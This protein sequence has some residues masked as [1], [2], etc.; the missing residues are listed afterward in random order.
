MPFDEEHALDSAKALIRRAIDNFKNR[1]PSK[2]AI[3]E[4][5]QPLV[6]G[7]SVDGDQV[8]AGRHLP[9]LASGR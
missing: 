8:H 4:A 2:V 6:A 1:D 9:R 3:P 7:F 5:S